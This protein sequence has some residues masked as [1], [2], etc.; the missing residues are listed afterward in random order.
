MLCQYVQLEGRA[1]SLTL[2]RVCRLE[3][4]TRVAKS[5]KQTILVCASGDVCS[6]VFHGESGKRMHEVGMRVEVGQ[7]FPNTA[8]V[9][10]PNR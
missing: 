9:D 2:Q 7:H 4:G 8:D 10:P 6:G 1:L 3:A 5:K